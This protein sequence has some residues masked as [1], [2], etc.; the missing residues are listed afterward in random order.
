MP[1]DKKTQ[2]VVYVG[3]K[4]L[5]RDTIAN[6]GLVWAGYGD[7]HEVPHTEAVQLLQH[8]D[9]W[10]TDAK[11]KSMQAPGVGAP[12]PAAPS[13][14]APPA[15]DTGLSDAGEGEG[16]GSNEGNQD[17]APADPVPPQQPVVATDRAAA[18]A[19]AIMSLNRDD[20]AHFSVQNGN[21]LIKA[22]RDAAND[23]TIGLKEINAAWAAIKAGSK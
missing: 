20:P 22:V 17:Q 8:P 23:Q 2:I 12:T 10:V 3:K 15:G 18:V 7:A 11:F 16:E 1:L 19:N 21:P 13:D 9:V 14:P 4:P 5:K 6:T